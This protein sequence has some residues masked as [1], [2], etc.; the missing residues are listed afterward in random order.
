M[1]PPLKKEVNM[2]NIRLLRILNA[3]SPVINAVR[4]YPPREISRATAAAACRF[5]QNWLQ[6]V[7][8]DNKLEATVVTG[9][10]KNTDGVAVCDSSGKA[11]ARFVCQWGLTGGQWCDLDAV[12]NLIRQRRR[13]IRKG[14]ER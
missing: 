12:L 6:K 7:I 13:R 5:V 14:G 9:V 2:S 4:A 8:E 10:S 11:I 3:P 1:K